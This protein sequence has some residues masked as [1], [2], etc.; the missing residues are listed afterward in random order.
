MNGDA[1]K[2]KAQPSIRAMQD[3][4][5]TSWTQLWNSSHQKYYHNMGIV[6]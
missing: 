1:V 3:K 4:K 2:E 5:K 6:N